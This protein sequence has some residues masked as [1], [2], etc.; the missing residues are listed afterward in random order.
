[1]G[2][3]HTPD[4]SMRLVFVSPSY[5]PCVG[6]AER[7]LEAVSTKL[8]RRGHDVTVLTFDCATQS[9]FKSLQGAGLPPQEFIDDVRVIRVHPDHGRVGRLRWWLGH[10]G[11]L[12]M[13]DWMTDTDTA[14][15]MSPPSGVGMVPSLLKTQADLICSVNW[16][17]GVS[18]WTG[19]AAK[20]RRLPHVGVPILH[21]DRP[22]ANRK[23]YSRMLGR[24]DGVIA[25]TEAE[26]DFVLARGAR[27]V[28]VS[29][30]GVEPSQFTSV[31]ATSVRERAGIGTSP[32]VGF[33]GR[34]DE[35][36]G[37]P[38]LIS[39]MSLVWQ[40]APGT[41][42][43]LAGQSA[44]RSPGVDLL[45]RSLP[46]AHR[47]QVVL[48][49]DFTDRDRQAILMACD[50]VAV[51]SVEE[52][53]GLVFVEAWMCGKPVIGADIPATRCLIADGKD[54]FV[55]TPFD[56]D[57]LATKLLDLLE[58][59]SRRRE[60]GDR[61]R[62]KVLAHHTWDQVADTWERTCWEVSGPSESS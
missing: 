57:H 21:I 47:G 54:G 11:G 30:A 25:L 39:A 6:G 61:G 38:T 55:V 50:V 5:T 48:I 1:M 42:L 59:P 35:G 40:H 4:H 7:L 23:L 15:S 45:L 33:I 29:G 32:V 14:F 27:S 13:P 60:F 22:W 62:A 49:D 43:L 18:Y 52:A 19:V 17:F 53:F 58:N 51:P 3:G 24:C 46:E 36:K 16:C 28:S 37:V 44:H 20:I 31:D 12:R 2:V 26:R 10:R 41:V 34:Q 56:N 8:A 9:D